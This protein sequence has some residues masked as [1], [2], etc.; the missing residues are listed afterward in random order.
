[1]P[2][3]TIG[4]KFEDR[5][6]ADF[7]LLEG[8]TIDRLYDV[9][10]GRRKIS[11]VSDFIAYKYPIHF[12]LEC[13]EIEEPRFNLS[14]LTQYDKLIEKKNIKGVCAGVV[15]WFSSY[16]RVCFVSIEEIEK[17]KSEETKSI[18]VKMLDGVYKGKSY[19]ILELP[20]EK[21]RKYMIT[22]YMP[23]YEWAVGRAEV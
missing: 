14:L 21:K 5:V 20:S 15:L 8:S 17:M 7:S 9:T 22:D 4:K 12:Y 3:K 19:E 13:K 6:Y 11:N 16:D 2:T 10:M 23:L 1:M 18:N